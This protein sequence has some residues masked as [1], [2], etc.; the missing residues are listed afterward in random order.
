MSEKIELVLN[1]IPYSKDIEATS[2]KI[3]E[4]LEK[5]TKESDLDL[6]VT[7]AN[8]DKR[9]RVFEQLPDIHSKY[10]IRNAVQGKDY[11]GYSPCIKGF[12]EVYD[13]CTLN[14]CV[15]GAWGCFALAENNPDCKIGFVAGTKYP[16]SAG[17]WFNDGKPKGYDDY[18]RGYT[19]RIGSVICYTNHVA[20]VNEIL[21]DGRLKVISSGYGSSSK[22]G[23][24]WYYV[25]PANGYKWTAYSQAGNFQGFIYPKVIKV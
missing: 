11:G 8:K 7:V 6:D 24:D 16:Q 9:V 23:L 14:N 3:I 13:G 25:S 4:Q 19:P 5:I 17:S 20:Y 15:G 21:E 10:F 18:E 12:I 22:N 1:V 2:Q